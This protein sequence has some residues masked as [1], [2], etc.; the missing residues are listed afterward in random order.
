MALRN[1]FD[2]IALDSTLAS[3]LAVLTAVPVT[4]HDTAT[5]ALVTSVLPAVAGKQIRLSKILATL[6]PVPAVPVTLTVYDGTT[7][8]T[9]IWQGD[10]A[11]L[12]DDFTPPLASTSGN[13]ITVTLAAGGSGV[14]GRLSI[15]GYHL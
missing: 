6:N 9:V 4:D 14:V 7:A 2:D 13:A 12:T 15:A 1:A 3:V 10:I 5:N 11:G 8:G